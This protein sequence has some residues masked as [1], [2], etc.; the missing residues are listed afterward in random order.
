[1]RADS[2]PV[3]AVQEITAGQGAHVVIDFVGERGTEAQG[4]AMLRRAGSY[5]VVG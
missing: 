5:F 3:I 2:D 1:V 4:V